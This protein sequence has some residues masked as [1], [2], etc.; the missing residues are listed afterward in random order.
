MIK[1]QLTLKQLEAFVCVVDIGTFRKAAEVL[2]TTQPNISARISALEESLGVILMHRDGRT[3][4]LTEQGEV[5]LAS[6]R[7]VLWSAEAFLEAAGR[8]DLVA[9]RLRLGVTELI[10]C[11]WLHAFLRRFREMYPSVAVELE[12]DLSAELDRALSEGRLD[13][14][15]QTGPFQHVTSASKNLGNCPY[16]WVAT[17]E[18]AVSVRSGRLADLVQATVLT[19]A[20]HSVASRELS[21]EIKARGLAHDRVVHSSS[22]TSCLQM[23]ADGMGV[24]LLPERLVRDAIGEGRLRVL[25]SDWLPPPLEFHARFDRAKMPRFVAVAADM[26]VEVA[27]DDF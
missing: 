1:S 18:V 26:A 14:A 22:L 5:L 12:V 13:L 6:A 23:A 20:R 2:G 10:A 4:Q 17:P 15:L 19:H 16:V 25:E 11:T 9:E 7:Q 3:L 24:A 8:R 27:G 21:R